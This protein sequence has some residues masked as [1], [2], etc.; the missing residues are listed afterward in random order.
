MNS[1]NLNGLVKFEYN[2]VQYKLDTFEFSHLSQMGQYNEFV[3]EN[4]Y[5]L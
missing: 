4:M 1:A 5:K 3:F 2:V